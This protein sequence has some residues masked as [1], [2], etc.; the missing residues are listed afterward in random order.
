MQKSFLHPFSFRLLLILSCIQSFYW[1][2]NGIVFKDFV[3]SFSC[4]NSGQAILLIPAQSTEAGQWQFFPS[5]ILNFHIFLQI[6]LPYHTSQP[7][8]LHKAFSL[9]SAGSQYHALQQVL[10]PE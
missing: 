5:A 6:L 8:L 4:N 9:L 10:I 2:S 1:F 3:F 7:V